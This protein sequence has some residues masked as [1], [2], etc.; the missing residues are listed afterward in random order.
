MTYGYARV[1][2]TGQQ[3]YGNGLDAQ[4]QE[5][6]NNGAE[7]IYREAFT[8]TKK[9]RPQLDLLMAALKE[10]DTLVITKLD[11]MARST[12][13]GLTLIQELRNKGVTLNV[14]N[15]GRFD[16]SPTGKLMFTILL[17][18]A[19]FERDMIAVR[20]QEG[21]AIARLNPDYKEGR[22]P[23]LYD[24]GLF[25]TLYNMVS[26]G[27]MS[28]TKAAEKLG[29]SRAKWY[30]LVK[31]QDAAHAKETASRDSDNTTEAC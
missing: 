3:L 11:R 19:E 30:R 13:D 4:E 25:D 24:V 2:S 18:F 28:A 21:K 8:G 29:I 15:M 27:E 10:G 23:A 20:T 7:I 14:L 26:A 31:E 16:Y 17:G 5:L 9:H 6:K 12:I 22:K 1:S